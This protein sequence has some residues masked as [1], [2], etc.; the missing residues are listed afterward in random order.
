[1][2]DMS[3]WLVVAMVAMMILMMGGM[4]LGGWRK[5]ISTRRKRGSGAE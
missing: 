2:M 3:T 5:W 1:M 4:L